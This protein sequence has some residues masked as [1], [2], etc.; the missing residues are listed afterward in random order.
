MKVQAVRHARISLA[1][2][3]GIF[4]GACEGQRSPRAVSD[5]ATGSSPVSGTAVGAR[6]TTAT[7]NGA[8]A[9]TEAAA[10][11][12]AASANLDTSL[13]AGAMSSEMT[14][15]L[16][17]LADANYAALVQEANTGEIDAAKIAEANASNPAV[18]AFARWMIR[19]HTRLRSEGKQLLTRLGL[20]PQPPADDPV[21]EL[22]S[23]A[24]QALQST[25]KGTSF[26]STYM[27]SQ[28][29]A[30][31]AVLGLL[32]TM[33]NSATNAQLQAMA[34]KAQPIIQSHLD[35]AQAI[36]SRLGYDASM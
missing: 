11:A 10:G 27:N 8:I 7:A 29:A 19:D 31:K 14:T 21:S 17:G 16:K 33:E 20:T 35:S 32:G 34:S 36:Q 5:S 22:N 1:I 26:D 30:H 12:S 24:T 28:V 13:D 9:G 4:L 18:K 3:A 6:D 2:A 15:R 23:R 25:A